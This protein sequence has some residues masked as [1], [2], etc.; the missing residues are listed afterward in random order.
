MWFS[1]KFVFWCEEV[2][3]DIVFFSRLVGSFVWDG[4]DCDVFWE[5]G[6]YNEV[7]IGGKWK[8]LLIV[9]IIYDFGFFIYFFVGWLMNEV[10]FF[11]DLFLMGILGIVIVWYFI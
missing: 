1:L 10:F 11:F 2:I 4:R 8:C 3:V 6:L 5:S 7:N 9:M